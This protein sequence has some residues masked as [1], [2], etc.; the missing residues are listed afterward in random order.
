MNKLEEVFENL[1]I[2]LTLSRPSQNVIMKT[3]E[4]LEGIN[5]EI[6]DAYAF[7]DSYDDFGKRVCKILN[8]EQ[9]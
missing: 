4:K 1:K 5:Y 9:E 7:S 3:I 8:L 2:R 6:T